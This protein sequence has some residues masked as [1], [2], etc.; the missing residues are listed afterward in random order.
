VYRCF[1]DKEALLQEVILGILERQ[2]VRMKTELTPK[3]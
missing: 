2:E 1:H 3:R